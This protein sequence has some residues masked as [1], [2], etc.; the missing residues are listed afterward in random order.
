LKK[1][2]YFFSNNKSTLP[3]KH[4]ATNNQQTSNKQAT[5]KQQTSRI[6]KMD[7]FNVSNKQKKRNRIAKKMKKISEQESLIA[8]RI[9]NKESIELRIAFKKISEEAAKKAII[10]ADKIEFAKEFERKK[11][12]KAIA[13]EKL[14][15][16]QKKEFYS[17]IEYITSF[18]PEEDCEECIDIDIP[19]NRLKNREYILAYDKNNHEVFLENTVYIFLLPEEH[20][21]FRDRHLAEF[22]IQHIYQLNYFR[23]IIFKERISFEINFRKNGKSDKY[24][25]VGFEE[26]SGLPPKPFD[27]YL[28]PEFWLGING[29]FTTPLQNVI[30]KFYENVN[31]IVE[32]KKEF[33]ETSSTNHARTNNI[34]Q[35]E[36]YHDI[37]EGCPYEG[38]E[39]SL[40]PKTHNTCYPDRATFGSIFI[41]F[42]L[43]NSCCK[44]NE[45]NCNLQCDI[46]YDISYNNIGINFR[47]KLWQIVIIIDE[48]VYKL[49]DINIINI[50]AI[51]HGIF[52]P[53]DKC[54]NCEL[55]FKKQ[56]A[57][58]EVA[59]TFGID[60]DELSCEQS[61]K[62]INKNMQIIGDIEY[63][64]HLITKDCPNW[65]INNKLNTKNNEWDSD[66]WDSD[67]DDNICY[68]QCQEC[69]NVKS[70]VNSG[71]VL[72]IK[73]KEF[74]ILK[75]PEQ[76]IMPN[77][78]FKI[79]PQFTQKDIEMMF[80]YSICL[81]KLP[82]EMIEY[83]LQFLAPNTKEAKW[84]I[85]YN[86]PIKIIQL[87]SLK[88]ESPNLTLAKNSIKE[89][90]YLIKLHNSVKMFYPKWQ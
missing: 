84:G 77:Y 27:T 79:D 75:F 69:K 43:K 14:F 65:C 82:I 28:K 55:E 70:L 45:I 39:C 13:E 53:E 59:D 7:N 12:A 18:Y 30:R 85:R 67:S 8:G 16:E 76:E 21:R 29:T 2:K 40:R 74:S 54:K 38:N 34:C 6:S 61:R 24:V 22:A 46:S 47:E 58:Q 44:N 66:E 42:T 25:F 4:Q 64:I 50:G 87:D 72:K 60:Y 36:I 51:S 33:F 26:K 31:Q 88:N 86:P 11:I 17:K 5:N 56:N 78:L 80:L 1:L 71:N 68:N 63:P 57:I 10:V 62:F 83:I 35:H 15:K 90:E 49:E 37:L 32:F 9:A 23:Y 19:K 3:K 20:D 41:P 89:K 52:K 81:G 48:L 73:C